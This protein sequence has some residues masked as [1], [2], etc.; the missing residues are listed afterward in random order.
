MAGDSLFIL[1]DLYLLDP[2]GQEFRQDTERCISPF[3]DV[4]S[5]SWDDLKTGGDLVPRGHRYHGKSPHSY[6]WQ[7]VPLQGWQENTLCM[8]SPSSLFTWAGWA[9]I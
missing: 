2:V 4:G 7:L 5:L 1:L 9:S 3:Y 8:T 6:G